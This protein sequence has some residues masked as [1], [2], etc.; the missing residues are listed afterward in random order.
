V[1]TPDPHDQAIAALLSGSTPLSES[2]PADMDMAAFAQ[3]C[4]NNG[5]AALIHE[6]VSGQQGPMKAP[7]PLLAALRDA[8]TRAVVFEAQHTRLLGAVGER[9]AAAGI[10]PLIF[11]GS[12][13]AYQIYELPFTRERCDTD[14]L[15]QDKAQALAAAALL[16]EEQ[17]FLDYTTAEGSLISYEKAIYKRD[18]LGLHH[19]LDLHWRISNNNIYGDTCRFDELFERG[20]PTRI[21]DRVFRTPCATD[22]FIIACL[23]RMANIAEDKEGRLIWLYDIKL[24]AERLNTDEWQTIARR[25]I[26][27]HIAHAC[28]MTLEAANAAFGGAIGTS[29][30][31]QLAAAAAAEDIPQRFLDSSSGGLV[32][33]ILALPGWQL[34]LRSILQV[35]FPSLD[36]MRQK[37][38]FR[39]AARAPYYYLRR[40]LSGT[41]NAMG[42]KR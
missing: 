37:Y 41:L 24:L 11:K 28:L 15:F 25:C 3:S 21:G 9:L 38:G 6:R 34:R 32:G 40:I 7:P 17:G 20:L 18:D 12:A 39:H 26:D 31:G 1:T 30:H 22:A 13:L 29:I 36:Y 27:R 19:E 5:V 8:T 23:H 10:Y 2:E 14:L 4:L 42:S 35:L 16:T 33:N